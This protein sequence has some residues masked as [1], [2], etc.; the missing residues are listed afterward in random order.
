M[1]GMITVFHYIP[2]IEIVN[3]IGGY[4]VMFLDM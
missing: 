2:S 4:V 1:R 3:K